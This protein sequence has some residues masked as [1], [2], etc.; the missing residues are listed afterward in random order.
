MIQTPTK[1]QDTEGY[2]GNHNIYVFVSAVEL[3]L[4]KVSRFA[5]GFS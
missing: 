3:I 2:G 5:K 4:Q 1:K